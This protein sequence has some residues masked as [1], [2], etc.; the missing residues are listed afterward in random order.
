MM[1]SYG[2]LLSSGYIFCLPQK[3]KVDMGMLGAYQCTLKVQYDM[4]TLKA[5]PARLFLSKGWL[6]VDDNGGLITILDSDLDKKVVVIEDLNLFFAIRQTQEIENV[7]IEI[8]DDMPR[9]KRWRF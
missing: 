6:A 8:M 3:G 5:I 7:W 2:Q 1:K 4:V 9:G